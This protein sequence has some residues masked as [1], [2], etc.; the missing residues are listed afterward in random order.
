[1]SRMQQNLKEDLKNSINRRNYVLIISMT[2]VLMALSLT[3]WFKKEETFSKSERRALEKFPGISLEDVMNGTFMEEFEKYSLDQFPFRDKF[4]SLKAMTS[5][6]IFGK[7]DNNDIYLA[8]GHLSKME[9]PMQTKMLDHAAMRI[10]DIYD[11]YLK[12]H[13]NTCYFSIVPDKNFFLAKENGYLSMDYETLISYMR[14]KVDFAEYIDISGFLSLEDYYRT[15]THWRQEKITDVA[16]YLKKVMLTEENIDSSS[17]MSEHGAEIS[18]ELSAEEKAGSHMDGNYEMKEL[19]IPFYG[20]Y[21]GQSALPVKP[22]KL[23][24]LDNEILRQC[25][26]SSY[27]TGKAKETVLYNMDKA[28]GNDPYEI[29]LSGT[30]A[31]QVIENPLAVQEKELIVFRDSFG[32]SLVPLLVDG[33]SKITVIDTRYVQSKI[34]GNLVEFQDQDVLFIYSTMIL[35]NSMSLR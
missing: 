26:V 11:M 10:Q 15:D 6:G 18:S 3:C 31:L 16:E 29:F 22:D 8:E 4:R 32:S 13:E 24:Y 30:S 9:Y 2:V 25:K 12:E 34:L 20:V 28:Y 33:Y 21:S 14:E 5:Y 35:N 19:E 27:D 17:I 23:F 1:M 7:K